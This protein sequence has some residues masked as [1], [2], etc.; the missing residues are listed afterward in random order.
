MSLT[1]KQEKFAQEV[2][3]AGRRALDELEAMRRTASTTP[4]GCR[5]A[6]MAITMPL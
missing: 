6:S 2:A 4:S 3:K 5:P 1:P